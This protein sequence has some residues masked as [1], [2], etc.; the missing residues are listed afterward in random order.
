VLLI[1]CCAYV[2][3]RGWVTS[4][5]KLEAAVQVLSKREGSWELE[6]RWDIYQQS[7]RRECALTLLPWFFVG[8]IGRTK[9]SP[10]Q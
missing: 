8:N 9:N 5:G 4:L 3:G 1:T 10:W 6:T 7:E 2:A